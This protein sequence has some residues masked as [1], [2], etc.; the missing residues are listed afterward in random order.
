MSVFAAA[1]ISALCFEIIPQ[2]L[3]H[4]SVL[5]VVLLLFVFN[6]DFRETNGN[7][8]KPD[9]F[10]SGI[11]T[12]TTDTGE[13][14]PIWA[15]SYMKDA[16]DGNMA[17]IGG[18]AKIEEVE[19]K[20]I[21]HVYKVHAITDSQLRENTLYFPGWNVFVDNKEIP[22]EYQARN[23]QGVM[24]FFVPKGEHTILIEFTDTKVRMLAN[25]T[26]GLTILTVIFWLIKNPVISYLKSK[27]FS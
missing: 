27:Y 17:V 8:Y 26:S 25:I 4:Y 9:S 19:R 16:R 13:S 2:K 3:K 24:T 7:F 14:S 21:K 5:V 18:N 11:Y 10:F 23:N 22:I 15:V 6:K 1:V 12:G 20:S